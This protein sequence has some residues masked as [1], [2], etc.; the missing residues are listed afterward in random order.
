MSYLG[1]DTAD[2]Q[3]AGA[4][5][6]FAQPPAAAPSVVVAD[7]RTARRMIKGSPT[8]RILGL[9]TS[10]LPIGAPS[11]VGHGVRVQKVSASRPL[12]VVSA[13]AGR[14]PMGQ[15]DTMRVATRVST[16]PE[17]SEEVTATR[18][19]SGREREI[20]TR[21]REAAARAQAEAEAAAA[22]AAA[23]AEARRK[24]LYYW[25]GGGAAVA[26]AAVILLRR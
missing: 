13:G 6:S 15:I 21:A 18:G 26:V 23:E 17:D 1:D 11:R 10:P 5:S 2:T 19:G 3:G 8:E 20:V 14:A 9:P 4:I 16:V 12:V 22:A 7:R 24:R 25:L